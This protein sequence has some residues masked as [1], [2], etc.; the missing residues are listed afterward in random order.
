MTKGPYGRRDRLIKEKR[1]DIHPS[2]NLPE[3]TLC[4]ECNAVFAGGRWLWGDVDT[5]AHKTLC[6]AC[7]RIA[8][9]FPAGYIQVKG[10]F[11]DDHRDEILNMIYNIEKQEKASRPLERIM[12]IT[13]K[14]EHTMITTTGIHIAR[15]IGE[16]L[17]SSYKGEYSFKYGDGEKRIRVYWER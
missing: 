11:F 12:A 2:E 7:R 10:S 17:S 13:K 5:S 15:K 14:R 9:D 16:S 6:P 8:S 4:R 1:H 3:R